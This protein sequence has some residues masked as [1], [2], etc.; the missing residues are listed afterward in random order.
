MKGK[1]I[2]FCYAREMFPFVRKRLNKGF[3]LI[4]RKNKKPFPKTADKNTR[5]ES[6]S[7]A[8][9]WHHLY[10]NSFLSFFQDQPGFEQST[11]TDL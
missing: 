3:S 9:Q 10:A 4:G 11:S 7:E 5:Q 6:L 1:P 8:T 2:N